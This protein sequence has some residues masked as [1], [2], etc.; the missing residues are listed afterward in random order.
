MRTGSWLRTT[1][2]VYGRA[3]PRGLPQGCAWRTALLPN[4]GLRHTE[5]PGRTQLLRRGPLT[6]Y[7]DGAHT[8]SSMQACVRWFRQAL[9]RCRRPDR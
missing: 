5:W 7:L 8:T 3:A 4:P 6:W 9:H 1:V 2:G